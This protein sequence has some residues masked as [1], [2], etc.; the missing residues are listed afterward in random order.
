MDEILIDQKYELRPQAG[1]VV[2]FTFWDFGR[3]IDRAR[4]RES[5]CVGVDD[6]YF[7]YY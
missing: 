6:H 7:Y 4:E 1:R 5:I 2:M 3:R